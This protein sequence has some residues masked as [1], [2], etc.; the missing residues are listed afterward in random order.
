[1]K[2][3]KIL[4]L[5]TMLFVLALSSF[6]QEKKSI[7][8]KAT[9]DNSLD[10]AVVNYKKQ[11]R[12][13]TYGSV[14]VEGKNINYQAVAGSLVFKNAQD[15]PIISMSY[16]AYFKRDED[17]NQRPITFV[18]NG[19]PGSATIWLHMGAWGP[20]RVYIEDTSRTRAPY[21]TVNNDYSLLDASDL[22]FI[23]APGTGFGQVITK[24]L[25]GAGDRKDFFGIDQDGR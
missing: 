3:T 22:V 23:D 18:Y 24:E 6:A 16:V 4:L 9:V 2:P 20:Q 14:T 15:T 19:G 1:M 17:P 11:Q 7:E 25:G 13:I 21:K 10:S 5:N 12:S 8:P